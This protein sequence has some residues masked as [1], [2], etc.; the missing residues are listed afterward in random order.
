AAGN[1]GGQSRTGCQRSDVAIVFQRQVNPACR[2]WEGSPMT[3]SRLLAAAASALV[4]MGLVAC[5]PP[6]KKDTGNQTQSG[7]NAKEATSASDFG[8]MDGLAKAAK[9]EVS[10]MSLRCHR[11]GRTTR[12]SSPRS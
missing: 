10:S 9:A 6:E 2:P 3:T 1:T 4:V 12:R 5:A 8:G 7:V 11:I